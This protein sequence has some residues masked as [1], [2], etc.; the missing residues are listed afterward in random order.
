MGVGDGGDG[1]GYVAR[2]GD[3]VHVSVSGLPVE[4]RDGLGAMIKKPLE[5]G[6]FF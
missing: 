3:E 5:M 1:V 6:F 2:G 4:V